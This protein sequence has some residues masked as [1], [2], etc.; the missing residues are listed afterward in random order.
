MRIE[1][2]SV[3]RTIETASITVFE[4]ESLAPFTF[5][6]HIDEEGGKYGGAL[7]IECE[8]TRWSYAWR[9]IPTGDTLTDFLKKA[10]IDYLITRVFGNVMVSDEGLSFIKRKAIILALQHALNT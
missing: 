4:F 7:N 9:E 3:I 6:Y 5:Q 1:K 10:G 8:G 2:S